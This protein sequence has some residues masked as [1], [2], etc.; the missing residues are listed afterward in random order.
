MA[1][2]WPAATGEWRRG[3][4]SGCGTTRRIRAYGGRF[5]LLP[6]SPAAVANQSAELDFGS[7]PLRKSSGTVSRSDTE[8]SRPVSFPTST[9]ARFSTSSAPW[10]HGSRA[11]GLFP[12][13]PSSLRPKAARRTSER[14]EGI[15]H[16]PA[17]H[18]AG[19]DGDCT[20]FI[21]PHRP[22]VAEPGAGAG[23]R[24]DARAEGKR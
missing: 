15:A 12:T 23:L 8:G 20:I 24:S 13:A 6:P 1:S 11:G 2:A 17:V 7:V 10:L 19:P 3:N 14:I 21:K 4:S 9:R 22:D 5:A 18:V 16:R